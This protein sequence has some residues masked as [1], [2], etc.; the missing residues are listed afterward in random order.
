MN[1]ARQICYAISSYKKQ[2]WLLTSITTYS[3][4][5]TIHHYHNAR[6]YCTAPVSVKEGTSICYYDMMKPCEDK[7]LE[8]QREVDSI[9]VFVLRVKLFN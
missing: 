9:G 5:I 8:Q 3:T 2:W 6:Y 4:I 1:D 7:K